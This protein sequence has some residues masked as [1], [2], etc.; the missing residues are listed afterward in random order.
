MLPTAKKAQLAD[1]LQDRLNKR[2]DVVETTN[3]KTL[4]GEVVGLSDASL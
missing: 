2:N 1:E 4:I 3:G